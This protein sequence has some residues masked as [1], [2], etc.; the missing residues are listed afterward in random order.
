[1]QTIIDNFEHRTGI[2]L[3]T[4]LKAAYSMNGN[5]GWGPPY[6]VLGLIGGHITDQGDDV[7][8]LYQNFCSTDPEDPNWHWPRQLM[9]IC[10]TGC[11]VHIC[12][13]VNS[14]FVVKFDP[15]GF[16]PGGPPWEGAF[17]RVA[18]KISEWLE[19]VPNERHDA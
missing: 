4:D 9:P 3:P 2:R 18:S 13:D 8:S 17:S 11:G 10:H 15:N 6:G 5:G 16:G 1:M 12:I 14:G 7:L 19:K